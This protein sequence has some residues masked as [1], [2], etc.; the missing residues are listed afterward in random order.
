MTSQPMRGEVRYFVDGWWPDGQ[1]H[2]EPQGYY[3]EQCCDPDGGVWRHVV[4]EH[5]GRIVRMTSWEF[6]G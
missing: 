2:E 3:Q 6:M 5:V 4:T 1:Q